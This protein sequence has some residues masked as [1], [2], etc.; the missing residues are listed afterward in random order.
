MRTLH[1]RCGH[2]GIRALKD[3]ARQCKGQKFFGWRLTNTRLQAIMELSADDVACT[4][5]S[6]AKLRKKHTGV[7]V[8]SSNKRWTGDTA[9]PFSRSRLGN[10]YFACWVAPDGWV[11]LSFLKSKDQS[12]EDL[13]TNFLVWKAACPAG[14][15]V[16]RTDRAGEFT[17]TA[18]QEWC[19]EQGI[20]QEFTAPDSS[21]GPAENK[22]GHL[23]RM[24]RAAMNAAGET[25][26]FLW[27]ECVAYCKDVSLMMPTTAAGRNG[28]SAWWRR[29]RTPAPLDRLHTWGCLAYAHIPESNRTR[30][31][32][33]GR[34]ARFM[35]LAKNQDDGWRFY[36]PSTRT[37][38]HSR[39][40][41]FHDSVTWTE[42]KDDGYV[43]LMRNGHYET[44]GD[45]QQQKPADVAAPA[46]EE[47]KNVE[48]NQEEQQQEQQQQQQPVQEEQ[49]QPAPA[50]A[51]EEKQQAAQEQDHLH[52]YPEEEPDEYNENGDADGVEE[53]PQGRRRVQR[54]FYDPY[55][56]EEQAAYERAVANL[57]VRNGWRQYKQP[58]RTRILRSGEVPSTLAEALE[59]EDSAF[60]LEAIKV[61]KDQH[62]I[63]RSMRRMLRKDL[64]PGRKT[65]KARWVFDIKKKKDG[66][67]ERYKARLVAKGFLQ[68]PQDYGNTFAP[69]PNIT[70][71][72]LAIACALALGF[73]VRHLDVKTAFLIPDLPEGERVY[74]EPPPG[75]KLGPEYVMELLKCIYGLKQSAAKWNEHID[76]LLREHN[77]VPLAGDAC[78]YSHRDRHSGEVDCILVLHVDDVLIAAPSKVAEATVKMLNA[79][80]DMK[81]LGEL[82]WYLGIKIA[83]SADRKT[84]E[85]SQETYTESMLRTYGMENCNPRDVPATKV[86]LRVSEN[87]GPM[88]EEEEH[89]MKDKPYREAVGALQYLSLCTRPDIAFAVNQVARH[90]NSPRKCHWLAVQQI[91]AYLKGTSDHGLRYTIDGNIEPTVL[92]SDSDW[93]G[94]LDGR[95]STNG[96]VA[97]FGGA[98]I[99]YNSSK[100]S[101]VARSSAEAELIALDECVKEA[102]WIR[103]LEKELD[104]SAGEP[105]VIHEDNEAAIAIS[106]AERRTKRTKHI[107]VKY[108][109]TTGNIK[110]GDVQV[111]PVP[112]DENP[113]DLFT[114]PLG[115][116]KLRKFRWMV[117][118]VSCKL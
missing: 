3:I 52:A 54:Q 82:S 53:R 40:A 66:T 10:T 110:A 112:S 24:A 72:R 14:F 50:P 57:T 39:S 41:T 80:Y 51:Q 89:F 11:E 61:E 18:F 76:K 12:V 35:G 22:I 56:F 20:K 83:Y 34:K 79:N 88:S 101:C 58:R 38:F 21:A 26:D 105:T 27:D 77:F 49:K 30:F 5:C 68:R 107:D 17:S 103:K 9:G 113:A 71:V 6:A 67:I 111:S 102:L 55:L 36:D 42:A 104:I 69:T 81:D 29:H 98:A 59:S 23:Q 63:N 2:I 73:D 106:A 1:E 64:P 91:F 87:M 7:K 33:H 70:S 92:F 46:A 31:T 44:C 86:L 97:I 13:K 16:L 75:S 32:D 78:V 115:R 109:A 19:K 108:F 116:V 28:T 93:A 15:G 60:W 84:V 45:R 85:L 8:T 96:M 118:V 4:S 94:D 47:E 25:T 43:P 117:G 100:Q 99:S 90:S 95:L 48:I 114:K 74:M 65:I 37:I 62:K